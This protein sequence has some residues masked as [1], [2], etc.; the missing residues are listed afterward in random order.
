MK[1][2]HTAAE[3]LRALNSL[4]PEHR[5]VLVEVHWRKRSVAE[6][7]PH[8]GLP[9]RTVKARTYYALRALR[10]VLDE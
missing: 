2:V 9:V 4:R 5:A 10:L 6:A 7:A 1:A 3:V 8:L